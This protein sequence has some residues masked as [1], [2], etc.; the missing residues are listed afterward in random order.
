MP[1]L[2]ACSAAK[3]NPLAYAGA[4][5]Y[6][7]EY[8]YEMDMDDA[9]PYPDTSGSGFEEEGWTYV[10]RAVRMGQSKLAELQQALPRRCRLTNSGHHRGHLKAWGE[11]STELPAWHVWKANLFRDMDGGLNT[12]RGASPGFTRRMLSPSLPCW[13]TAGELAVGHAPPDG[14]SGVTEREDGRWRWPPCGFPAGTSYLQCGPRDSDLGEPRRYASFDEWFAKSG[15][16][17]TVSSLIKHAPSQRSPTDCL[18][19][20]LPSCK[21]DASAFD[22]QERA[23]RGAQ[24]AWTRH[25]HVRVALG[26]LGLSTSSP[27]SKAR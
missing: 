10:S 17:S 18:T 25:P 14:A 26:A 13:R 12:L 22:E 21:R 15:S 7:A 1:G 23:A 3:S 16:G 20:R 11:A 4:Q 8:L 5:A 27:L 24:A 19:P 9:S 2:H 6:K